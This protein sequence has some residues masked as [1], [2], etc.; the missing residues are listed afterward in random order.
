MSRRNGI[1]LTTM[2]VYLQLAAAHAPSLRL[3]KRNY[4]KAEE[5]MSI[6][7]PINI[8]NDARKPE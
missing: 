3:L 5:P 8:V 1:G 6:L 7:R 4:A 2:D